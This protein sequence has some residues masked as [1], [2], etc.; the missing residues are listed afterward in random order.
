L[1]NIGDTVTHWRTDSHEQL[2]KAQQGLQEMSQ[3]DQLV[4]NRIS[5]E[6]WETDILLAAFV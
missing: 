2:V 1:F 3:N 6:S 5:Q 4:K